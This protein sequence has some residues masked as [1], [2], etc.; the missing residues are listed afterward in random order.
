VIA[1]ELAADLRDDAAKVVRAIGLLSAEIEPGLEVDR[2][3]LAE[4]RLVLIELHRAFRHEVLPF[5]VETAEALKA[6]ET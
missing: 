5:V 6:S 4:V 1:A 3:V 2:E